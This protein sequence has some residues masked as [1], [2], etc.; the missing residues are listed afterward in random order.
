MFPLFLLFVY[1]SLGTPF[2]STSVTVTGGIGGDGTHGRSWSIVNA[3]RLLV[4]TGKDV[5]LS[6]DGEGGAR[7]ESNSI[8]VTAN[9][10]ASANLGF[11]VVESSSSVTGGGEEGT[12][13]RTTDAS[14]V[15][16]HLALGHLVEFTDDN[17][18]VGLQAD[19]SISGWYNLRYLLRQWNGIDCGTNAIGTSDSVVHTCVL[20]TSDGVFTARISVSEEDAEVDGTPVSPDRVKVDIGIANWFGGDA[21]LSPA[22]AIQRGLGNYK[23]PSSAADQPNARLGLTAVI[24]AKTRTASWDGSR[25]VD[26]SSGTVKV[27]GE[28]SF[29]GGDAD[30]SAF[31]D[32]EQEDSAGVGVTATVLDETPSQYPAHEAIQAY[33]DAEN[34]KD[35]V[36]AKFMTF[37]F[38]EDRVASVSW[39]P[40]FA[41]E[42]SPAIR[43]IVASAVATWCLA[44]AVFAW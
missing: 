5:H 30:T 2:N 21:P 40:E 26:S 20:S 43:P 24:V 19:D 35:G 16:F 27:E 22:N 38:N 25:S 12:T 31:F 1:T 4:A 39:D 28:L 18:I 32:W 14:L 8:I 44:A 29:G 41:L 36:T 6:G 37:S 33:L 3:G 9:T 15:G 11:A 10:I 23:G 7:S 42:A 34:S 17:G 13:E